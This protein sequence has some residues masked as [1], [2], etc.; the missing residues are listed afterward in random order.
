MWMS[1]MAIIAF[2]AIITP[3]IAPK[4]AKY[5]KSFKSKKV[6]RNPYDTSDEDSTVDTDIK[7]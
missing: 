7:N 1:F 5:F 3:K 2:I 6:W 4:I